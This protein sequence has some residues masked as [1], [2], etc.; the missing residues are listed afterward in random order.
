MLDRT[1]AWLLS[2][3]DGK[4]GC[5]MNAKALDSFGRAPVDTTNAYVVWALIESGEKSLAKEIAAVKA[6]AVSSQD[7]YVVALGANILAATGDHAGARQ[8]MD[9]LVK[10]QETAG[11]VTGAVTGITRSGGDALTIETTALAVLAWMRDPSYAAQVQKGLQWIVESNKSGR[12]GSTQST[13][14]AL[15]SI[16]AY[17][18]ANARPKAPGRILLS[19]DG[20]VLGTPLAF[21]AGN[22][23]ALVMPDFTSHLVPGTHTVALKMEDGSSMPFS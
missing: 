15:R 20:K 2:R 4:G 9:K 19:V 23:G 6:S 18:N 3:R 12:F 1:P 11:N 7:S 5:N 10:K 8:L 13:V 21:T 22:Q 16:V 17:D 14:L